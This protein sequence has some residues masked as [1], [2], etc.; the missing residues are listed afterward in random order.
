MKKLIIILAVAFSSCTQTN[1]TNEQ[2]QKQ[3]ETMQ[4]ELD[5]LKI[6]VKENNEYAKKEVGELIVMDGRI[7]ELMN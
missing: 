1:V 2:Y 6:V 4:K 7:I 3:I 5:S